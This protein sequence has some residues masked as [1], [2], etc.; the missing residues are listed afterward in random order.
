MGHGP[1]VGINDQQAAINH[2]ENPLHL[3]AE[4]RVARGVNNVDTNSFVID[5]G[6]FGK[7][8]D[9]TLTLKIVGVH[10][11]GRNRLS[12]AEDARLVE[13]GI[14]QRGFAM[15]NVG[16]DRN[17]ANRRTWVCTAHTN[18][19]LLFTLNGIC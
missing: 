4:I 19:T 18:K 12:L 9:T 15:V 5:G 11:T 16:N 13:H 1:F 3:T 14:H 17:V 2:A 8:C 6:V 10:H 7:N